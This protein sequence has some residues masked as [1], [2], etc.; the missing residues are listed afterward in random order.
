MGDLEIKMKKLEE[1]FLEDDGTV[2]A[3]PIGKPITIWL[4]NDHVMEDSEARR[5]VKREI[6]KDVPLE[7]NA[8]T[9]GDSTEMDYRY[10]YSGNVHYVVAVQYYRKNETKK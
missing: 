1:L 3:K 10:G 4:K 5:I 2:K 7:A 6:L 9:I 8:C